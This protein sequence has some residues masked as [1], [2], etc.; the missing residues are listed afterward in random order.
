MRLRTKAGALVDCSFAIAALYDAQGHINGLLSLF[1]NITE[2]KHAEEALR[3]REILRVELDKQRELN[4]LKTRFISMVSHEYRNPLA[5]ILVTSNALRDYMEKMSKEQV[6]ERLDRIKAQVEHMTALME[7]VLEIGK[8]EAG[9]VQFAPTPTDLDRLCRD[10]VDE[11]RGANSAGQ[12]LTYTSEG[13]FDGA[14][15][16]ASLMRQIVTNLLSN[17]LKYT[18]FGQPRA[19]LSTARRPYRDSARRRPGDRHTRSGPEAALHAVPPRGERR[20]RRRHGAGAC[21]CQARGRS[22]RRRDHVR[23]RG[24][25]GH[26]LY[27]RVALCVEG[28]DGP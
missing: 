10:I 11:F 8:L 28:V 17:A 18:P 7:E 12:R 9:A 22:S 26:D 27:C 2:Q 16:D 4:Q 21:H 20:Q 5:T 3:E 1:E 13:A 6:T 14:N 25:R 23:E 15:I 19:G 24:R